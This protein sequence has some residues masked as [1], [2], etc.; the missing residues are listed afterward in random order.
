MDYRDTKEEAEF[1]IRLRDW[2]T[3]HNPAGWQYI[4]DD[5]GKRALG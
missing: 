1:R 2:L 4:H 5:A 3:E